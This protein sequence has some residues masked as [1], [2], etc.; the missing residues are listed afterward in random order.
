MFASI[1]SADIIFGTSYGDEGKG[2]I[3]ASYAKNYDAVCRWAGGSNAGHT[4]ILN[5][6]KIVTHVVPSGIVAGKLSIVGPGCVLNVEKFLSEL[7]ELEAVGLDISLVKI[8]PNCHI[9]Q[10][11]HI[12][13]DDKSNVI[14]TTVNGVGPTYAD[15][16]L[17]IGLRAR[18]VAELEPYIL[19]QEVKGRILCE[20]AQGALLDINSDSYPYVTSSETMPYA[21]CSLGFS[22]KKIGNIIAVAKAYETRVGEDPNFPEPKDLALINLAKLGN[23]YGATTGRPRRCRWLDVDILQDVL[24]RSGATILHINKCD[25]LQAGGVYVYKYKDAEIA[26]STMNQWEAHI[27]RLLSIKIVFNYSPKITE[28]VYA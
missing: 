14:G 4:I 15:K 11:F 8:H 2:K 25:I 27:K 22:H 23:E 19:K 26:C 7:A 9:V 13:D 1:E 10:D 16:A 20:G 21:A 3:V 6:K 18:D 24:K 17:R 5:G 28:P 12:E